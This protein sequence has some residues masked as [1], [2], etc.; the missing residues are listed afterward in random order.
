MK[1]LFWLPLL[2]AIAIAGCKPRTPE[3]GDNGSGQDS[4]VGNPPDPAP[5]CMALSHDEEAPLDPVSAGTASV[6]D[7]C[8][9]LKLQYGGGCQ[10]HQFKLLWDGS[11]MESMPPQVSLTLSHNSN[12]DRCRSML[13]STESFDIKDLRYGGLDQVILNIQLPGPQN[14][15]LSANYTYSD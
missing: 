1:K 10:E 12:Q 15:V 14:R 5:A 13:N 11:W 3:N 8:L 7:D 6:E 2:L 9:H 4:T